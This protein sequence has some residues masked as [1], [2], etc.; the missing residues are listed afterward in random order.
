MNNN[1]NILSIDGGGSRGIIPLTILNF[2]YN[3]DINVTKKYEYYTGS[4]VGVLIICMLLS[5]HINIDIKDINKLKDEFMKI[6]TKIFSNSYY[7]MITTLYGYIG[8]KYNN[9]NLYNLLKEYFGDLTIGDLKGKIIIPLFDILSNEI[10]II[11]TEKDSDFKVIDLIM[12]STAAPT[13]FKSYEM[14][15]QNKKYIFI[16]NGVITNTQKTYIIE[17]LSLKYKIEDLNMLCIGTGYFKYN[18]INNGGI[19]N[20]I[21]NSNITNIFMIADIIREEYS[22]NILLKNRYKYI[23]IKLDIIYNIID[24]IDKKT[25]YKLV[26]MTIEYLENN[27]NDIIQNL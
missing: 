6:V 3:N 23:N 5:P 9:I 22:T 21:S 2:L 18:F 10:I 16:D 15:Y 4:S 7:N 8:P 14:E 1:I 25:L 24:I 26:D 19:L 20:W 11:D 27:K 17:K 12:A 13:Y